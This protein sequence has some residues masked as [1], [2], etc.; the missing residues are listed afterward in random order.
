MTLPERGHY[1]FEPIHQE[2]MWLAIVLFYV[3][4]LIL[5]GGDLVEDEV[6][7][8]DPLFWWKTFISMSHSH[9]SGTIEPSLS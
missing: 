2:E 5:T 8:I 3:D 4:D 1:G 6:E 9:L 7:P